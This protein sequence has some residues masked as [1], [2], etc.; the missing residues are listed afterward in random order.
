[1][2]NAKQV[3]VV[4]GCSTGLGRGCVV[5]LS[6]RPNTIV[7]A[8]ARKLDAIKDL[9]ESGIAEIMEC[10]VNS[11]A[12]LKTCMEKAAALG[13][14]CV[15]GVICN[16]GLS[17]FGPIAFQSVEE[18]KRVHETNVFGVVRTVQAAVPFM[19]KPKC[20]GGKIAIVGS[21]SATF[22]TPFA[23]AYC[24]SKASVQTFGEALR[25]EL[26]PFGISVTNLHVGCVKSNFSVNA[27][28]NSS[29][30]AYKGGMYDAVLDKIEARIH[31]SQT[32]PATM[33]AEDA[34]AQIV[35]K[36]FGPFWPAGGTGIAG[37][38]FKLLAYGFVQKWF[39]YWLMDGVMAGR[40]GLDQLRITS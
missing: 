6:K 38:W 8:T 18:M 12:S 30:G 10:D 33:D 2:A 31:A 36:V 13:G 3:I 37:A 19:A 27:A 4:T 7:V 29:M 20:R 14:G 28:G 9:K 21:V 17:A 11:E 1:M 23:G 34:G 22:T 16:A 39:P 32:N 24:A 35:R 25:M 5:A 40:F 15:D 26:K